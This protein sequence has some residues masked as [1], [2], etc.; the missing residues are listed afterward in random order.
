MTRVVRTHCLAAR[1]SRTGGGVLE[2]AQFVSFGPAAQI[3]A[4]AH[5]M[6]GK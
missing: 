1:F 2:A 4:G 3:G 6:T 5:L